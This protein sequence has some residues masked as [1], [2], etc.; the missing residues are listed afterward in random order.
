MRRFLAVI[1]IPLLAGATLAGCSSS[2]SSDPTAKSSAKASS[3][4]AAAASCATTSTNTNANVSVT[5][6]Y[7]TTPKVSFP[8]TDA[9]SQL[10]VK[11]LT[12]GT[13]P[14]VTKSNVFVGN[15]EVYVW[16]GKKQ[17]LGTST[18]TASAS[19]SMFS[20]TGLIPGLET[21]LVGQKVGSRVLIVIPPKYGFGTAGSSEAGITGTDTLV[22][23]FDVIGTFPANTSVSGTQT[24]AGSGLPTVSNPKTAG[25][26][27]IT[28]PANTKAPTSLVTKTLITGTGTKVA[29][30]DY[31]VV[32]YNA[33]IWRTGK[34]FNS[35]W[36]SKEP[37]GFEIDDPS[38]GMIAGWDLGLAGKTVG[39][40]VLLVIPPAEGYGKDGNSQAGIKATDTMVFVVDI[41][42]DYK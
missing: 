9:S 41:I 22:F 26:E 34:V 30:G 13:G 10:T 4:S 17:T 38:G 24:Q 33:V 21:G 40:R 15:Y 32:Q 31:V 20:G 16:C 29:A 8:S 3:T 23:V 14:T 1:A 19:P 2:K 27:T 37:F 28:I 5:G 39:S 25:A 6:A 35:S 11:T 42:A 7:G 18:F 12:T 36:A